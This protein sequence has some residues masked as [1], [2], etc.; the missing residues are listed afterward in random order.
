MNIQTKFFGNIEIDENKVIKFE[1]G[2]PGFEDLKKFLFMTDE[3]AN[4]PFCWLQ[5]IEDVNIVFTL[6]NIFKFIPD[7][8]PNVDMEILSKLGKIEE[9][10]LA[11]YC[12]ANIPKNIKDMTVNLKAPIIINLFNNNAKQIICNNDDYSIKYYV[13]KN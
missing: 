4:S 7:Y 11:I 9:E 6:I 8:N 12:I 13:Y 5:S 1:D 10:N 3:D 2:I